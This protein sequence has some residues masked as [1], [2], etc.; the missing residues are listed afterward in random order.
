MSACLA[1]FGHN[2]E[3]VAFERTSRSDTGRIFSG[4]D[5]NLLAFLVIAQLI[6]LVVK[7]V[8]LAPSDLLLVK[9]GRNFGKEVFEARRSR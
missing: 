4:L 6:I 9:R 1:F 2:A 5:G 8:S 3:K 7:A